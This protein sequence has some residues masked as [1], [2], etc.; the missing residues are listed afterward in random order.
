M[1]P[2][3]APRPSALAAPP[4][5]S[6]QALVLARPPKPRPAPRTLAPDPPHAPS[7]GVT[8]W[9]PTLACGPALAPQPEEGG[10]GGRGTGPGDGGFSARARL[11]TAAAAAPDRP[12]R[13]P[14]GEARSTEGLT[15]ERRRGVAWLRLCNFRN[16]ARLPVG[17]AVGSCASH[18]TFGTLVCSPARDQEMKLKPTFA[19]ILRRV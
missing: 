8:P 18:F 15:A 11:A 5:P 12:R 1:T 19:S 7:A 4:R 2:P 3:L 16:A 6:P 9:T 14:Q 10:R 17:L 13:G